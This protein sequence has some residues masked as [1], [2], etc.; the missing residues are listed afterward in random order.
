MLAYRMCENAY[1]NT[2]KASG[3]LG[4]WNSKGNEVLY[5]CNDAALAYLENMIRRSGIGFSNLFSL[6]TIEYPDKLS[7][8]LLRE[9][10]PMLTAGWNDKTSYKVSQSIGDEW[11]TYNKACILKVP[12][13][14]IPQSYNIVFNTKHPD[15]TQVKL[16]SVS[17]FIP[18][19]RLE[20][21]V[22]K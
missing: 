7:M 11:Y 6:M 16:I 4:R 14:L 17:P 9:G 1:A 5:C 22:K 20:T 2:L 10:D 8:L 15:F 13:V 21:I 12:S 18:D 3:L 19:A